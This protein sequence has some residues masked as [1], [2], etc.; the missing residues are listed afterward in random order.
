MTLTPTID[1][2]YAKK[3]VD[4]YGSMLFADVTQDN[5]NDWLDFAVAA[6]FKW[7][8]SDWFQGDFY[9]PWKGK[10]DSYDSLKE[11]IRKFRDKG[12]RVAVHCYMNT[13]D[14]NSG[15]IDWRNPSRDF[16]LDLE[17]EKIGTIDSIGVNRNQTVLTINKRE[18][19]ATLNKLNTK[20]SD[21]LNGA[22]INM[23]AVGKSIFTAV[24]DDGI[25]ISGYLGSYGTSAHPPIV[26]SDVYYLYNRTGFF[27]SWG[28]EMQ[29]TLVERYAQ[30]MA[31]CEIE[32]T[33]C[34]GYSTAQG[35][36]KQDYKGKM[37]A[38]WENGIAPY[39]AANSNIFQLGGPIPIAAYERV[40]FV[41]R[42]DSILWPNETWEQY[43]AR[44]SA[45]NIPPE[46][47]SIENSN[48]W[49]PLSNQ[50][51]EKQLKQIANLRG[52]IVFQDRTTTSILTHPNKNT[53][54]K[55][56]K[57]INSIKRA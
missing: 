52:R 20:H 28:S 54:I 19:D 53:I 51:T 6:G 2:I 48:G 46:I 57:E 41:E 34:D 56:L 9:T 14:S 44:M 3:H 33:Y 47:L 22:T 35:E 38:H 30:T 17:C 13:I 23:L 12:I 21:M 37:D 45:Q 24:S 4:F 26:G 18:I 15:L 50:T 49:W 39:A 36:K 27:A 32:Y 29:K 31:D 25:N 7:I 40:F 8:M 16:Y 1:G 5:F 42:G 10:F 11:A 55:K 43:F